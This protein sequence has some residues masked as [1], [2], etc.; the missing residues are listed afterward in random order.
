MLHD[1]LASPSRPGICYAIGQHH[2]VR[3]RRVTNERLRLDGTSKAIGPLSQSSAAT[4]EVEPISGI[5]NGRSISSGVEVL[6]YSG[7]GPNLLSVGNKT[8][9]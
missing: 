7:E 2:Y 8:P 5:K 6:L 9:G 3:D 1:A 4:Y